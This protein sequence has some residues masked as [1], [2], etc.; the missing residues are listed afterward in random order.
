M[1]EDVIG[2]LKTRWRILQQG[3]LR[4]RLATTQKVIR[5]VVSL[6]NMALEFEDPMPED[7][8]APY[9]VRGMDHPDPDAQQALAVPLSRRVER[10]RGQAK[11][12]HICEQYF[13]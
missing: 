4:T 12:D 13:S 3:K 7:K 6:H 8:E 5:A 9:V 1:T 10:A 11:R 2:L